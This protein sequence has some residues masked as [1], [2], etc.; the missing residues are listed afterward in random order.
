MNDKVQEL[1]TLKRQRSSVTGD[2]DELEKRVDDAV[3]SL[4]H[5]RFGLVKR[6]TLA[7]RQRE[8]STYCSTIVSL[9]KQINDKMIELAKIDSMIETTR[10][11]I[12]ASTGVKYYSEEHYKAQ[13]LNDGYLRTID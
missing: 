9:G 2:I 8:L 13:I 1:K 12:I 5:Y 10:S 7:K 3:S 6:D 11:S 4:H